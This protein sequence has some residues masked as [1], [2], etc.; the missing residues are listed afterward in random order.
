MPVIL[1]PDGPSLGGFVCPAVVAAAERWKLGQLRPGDTVRLVPWSPAQAAAA[2]RRRG[3]LARPGHD[4]RSSRV[5]RPVWNAARARRRAARRRRAG[6][7]RG[8]RRRARRSPTAG[9]ATASCSSSTAPMTLDLELRL[10]VHALDQWVR[11]P[12]RPTASSTPPPASAR[13]S[14]RSTATGSP[15][16]GPLDA[17]R[18]GARTS[19]PTSPTSRSPRGSCTC[20]CRGTTRRPARRSSGTCTACAPTRRGA[21]GTSS[22]SA[23]STGS[24]SVDDVHRIVFDA[25]VPR[26]RA[27]RRVPRRAGGDAARPAPPAGD[28]EVQPG[29]HV[30]AGELGRHRRRV[31]VHLRHGGPRR[32]PVRRAHRAGVEPRRAAARTSSQPWLLRTFDQLRWYPV[33]ADELLDDARGAGA[34][35]A[36]HQDRG[37]HVPPARA[38][39]LPRRARRRDRHL[40]RPCSSGRSAPSASSGRAT[41]SSSR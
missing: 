23:G 40:P 17:L 26:A 10:R 31:P 38:P 41:G 30:D 2:D 22:S 39:A 19:S 12:P 28:H 6:P 16:S 4:A 11:R 14:C 13:C 33:E 25:V 29:A 7:A 34:R 8:D 18:V 37:D 3:R 9:P 15:S 32:L 1:G 35:R 36:G 27:R 20:R 24:T 21:R 5:A